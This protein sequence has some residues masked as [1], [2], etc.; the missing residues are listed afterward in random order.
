MDQEARGAGIYVLSA[1]GGPLP[2][3]PVVPAA[4]GGRKGGREEEREGERGRERATASA[5]GGR[6]LDQTWFRSI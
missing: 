5:P 2:S 3:G 1:E 6:P 4:A